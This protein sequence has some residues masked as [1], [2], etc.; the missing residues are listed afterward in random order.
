MSRLT[1]IK[2]G[3]PVSLTGQ[4]QVQGRQT[5]AGLTAWADDVNR[6]GGLR[7]GSGARSISLVHHDDASGREA[8]KT[9]TRRLITEDRVDILFGPYSS[10]LAVTAAEVAEAHGRLMWNQGGASGNVYSRGYRWVVGILTPAEE[11]LSGL[12]DAIRRAAPGSG[13]LALVWARP[14]AFL[15]F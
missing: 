8:V 3:I 11:Y 15:R 4:F 10:V 1:P 5:L 14:G 2:I 7:F 13:A 12:L 9:A 6:A